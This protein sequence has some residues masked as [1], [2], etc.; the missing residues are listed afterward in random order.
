MKNFNP[1]ELELNLGSIKTVENTIRNLRYLYHNESITQDVYHKIRH[2]LSCEA[3]ELYTT[4]EFLKVK[5]HENRIAIRKARIEARL[6]RE[7]LLL[8]VI[9]SKLNKEERELLKLY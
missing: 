6:T 4:R 8:E 7:A 1:R 5:S 2:Q 9:K 3:G